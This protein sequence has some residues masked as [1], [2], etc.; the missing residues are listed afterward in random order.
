MPR[1]S[2]KK[3]LEMSMFINSNGRIEYNRLCRAC[4]HGCKQ[5]HKAVI[6]VCPKYTPRQKRNQAV[7]PSKKFFRKL[8]KHS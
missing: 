2:S 5:S 3:Q 8:D 1:M 6:L 7:E 4:A